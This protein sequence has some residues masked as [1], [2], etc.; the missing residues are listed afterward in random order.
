MILDRMLSMH[1]YGI[2][3]HCENEKHSGFHGATT[4][5]I[6]SFLDGLGVGLA[7][8]VST[9]VGLIVAAA[10]LAHDFSD[11]INTVNYILKTKGKSKTAMTWLIIDAVAPLLGIISTFFFTLS[12]NALGLILAVF[13]GF[14]LYIGASDLLPE[15]HHRHPKI[16]TTLMTILGMA[17]LYLAIYFAQI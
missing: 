16:V 1:S 6:H 13:C 10:V 9:S 14:F 7:F 2:D 17:V 4:L 8:K 11:G 5:A 15:S 3:E 12:E